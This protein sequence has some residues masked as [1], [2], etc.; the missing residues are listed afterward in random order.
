LIAERHSLD[1]VQKG[2]SEAEHEA[3]ET[4][5][6]SKVARDRFQSLKKQ[7]YVLSLI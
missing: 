6:E 7:R 4:R 1:E 2:L 5:K 3:D